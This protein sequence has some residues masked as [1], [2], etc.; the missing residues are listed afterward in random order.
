MRHHSNTPNTA[1][2]GI[3]QF[4]GLQKVADLLDV[5]LLT[6]RRYIERGD[7][8]SVKIGARRLIAEEDL[9]AFIEEARRETDRA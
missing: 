8:I 2:P 9:R 7:L 1:G 5:N 3:G 4:Y 6:V